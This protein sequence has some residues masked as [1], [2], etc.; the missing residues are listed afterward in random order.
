MH[1]KLYHICERSS[2][3]HYVVNSESQFEFTQQDT[4]FTSKILPSFA[5]QFKQYCL[6]RQANDAAILKLKLKLLPLPINID[7]VKHA[8]LYAD[9][10]EKQCQH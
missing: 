8:H 10:L 4:N 7:S 6:N 1:N 9:R 2:Q 3:D 5:C